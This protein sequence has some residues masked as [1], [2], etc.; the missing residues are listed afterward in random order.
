[1]KPNVERLRFR[2]AGNVIERRGDGEVR[3]MRSTTHL[4]VFASSIF[5]GDSE[6]IVVQSNV[7]KKGEVIWL[8]TL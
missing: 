2:A 4:A 3:L 1:V 7:G 8:S 6:V 5:R